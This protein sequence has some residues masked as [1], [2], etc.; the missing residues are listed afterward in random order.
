MLLLLMQP[1]TLLAFFYKSEQERKPS[2]LES[3]G[4][5]VLFFSSQKPWVIVVADHLMI[6][7]VKKNNKPQKLVSSLCEGGEKSFLA[8]SDPQS[9]EEGFVDPIPLQEEL[10][11]YPTWGSTNI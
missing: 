9:P 6:Q 7:K 8:T 4:F 5:L 1:K 10:S 2:S 3:L 11:L